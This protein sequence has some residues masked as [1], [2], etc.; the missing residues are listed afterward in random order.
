MSKVRVKCPECGA[1]LRTN[2]S[3]AGKRGRCPKCRASILIPAAPSKPKAPEKARA[4]AAPEQVPAEDRPPSPETAGATEAPSEALPAEDHAPAPEPAQQPEE[5]SEQRVPCPSCAEPIMP[6]AA[7]CRF[8]GH[9]IKPQ[10]APGVNVPALTGLGLA[11]F[12]WPAFAMCC[13][14]IFK[15]LIQSL[16]VGAVIS[17]AALGCG[18]YGVVLFARGKRRSPAGLY[19]A[20]TAMVLGLFG[21]TSFLL[22]AVL[23][24]KVSDALPDS[25]GVVKQV[26]GTE[27][28][29][30]LPMQCGECGHQFEVTVTDLLTKMAGDIPAILAPSGDVNE[31]LDKLDRKGGPGFVCPKCGKPKAFM[32]STCPKCGKKFLPDFYTRP[33]AADAKLA[34]PYCGAPVPLVATELLQGVDLG[35]MLQKGQPDSP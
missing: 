5:T 13:F 17:A 28:L 22:Y 24:K 1:S 15:Q 9:A 31:F 4:E 19:I 26:L 21:I 32:M 8:C 10:A 35:K 29:K 18:I 11:L 34:C 16:M 27:E 30:R 14:L 2:A 23:T 25:M 20:L 3:L 33:G 6:D 12:A 7:K